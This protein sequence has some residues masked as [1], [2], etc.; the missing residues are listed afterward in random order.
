[1][2]YFSFLPWNKYSKARVGKRYS[3]P[4]SVRSSLIHKDSNDISE[5]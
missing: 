1:M 2:E 5:F 4:K 3:Q